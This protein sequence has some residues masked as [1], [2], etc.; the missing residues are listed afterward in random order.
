MRVK[1][2]MQRWSLPPAKTAELTL[3]YARLF[4]QFYLFRTEAGLKSCHVMSSGTH[5]SPR[6]LFPSLQQT[7]GLRAHQRVFQERGHK[8]RFKRRETAHGRST[9]SIK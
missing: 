9:N 5:V 4:S 1:Q 2:H 3:T 8:L 7:A 6:I